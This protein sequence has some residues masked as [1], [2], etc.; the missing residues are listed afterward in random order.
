MDEEE[1]MQF[2]EAKDRLKE[3]AEGECHVLRYK[4]KEYENGKQETLCFTYLQKDQGNIC[5][6]GTRF[7]ECF[8]ILTRRLRKFQLLPG[9]KHD[10]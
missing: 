2:R 6:S 7:Q 9:G 3:L 1:I 4:L 10:N 8:D 5:A